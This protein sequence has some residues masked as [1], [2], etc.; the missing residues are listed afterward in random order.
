M[1]ADG[2]RVRLWDP[3][4]IDIKFVGHHPPPDASACRSGAVLDQHNTVCH[5]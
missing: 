2:R 3:R 4:R 1:T 5:R